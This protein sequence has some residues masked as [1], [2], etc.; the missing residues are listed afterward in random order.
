MTVPVLKIKVIPKPIIKGRMDV[1]FPANVRTEKFLKV[2]RA[3][4]TYTFDIDYTLMPDGPVSSSANAY[5]AVLDVASGLYLNVSLA[6][7]LT[8]GLDADL[9][10]IAALTGTGILVRTA[11]D[12]W[13]QRSIV[14]GA[15]MGVT[16][17]D[18]VAGNPTITI[19]DPELVALAGLTSAADKLPYFDGAGSAALADFTAYARSLLDDVDAGTA[20]TT[21][22]LVIGTD[23]QAYDSDLD[24]W[25][26]KTAPTGDAVGTSDAQTLT[27]KTFDVGDN[28]V[29][30]T[31]AEFN[32]ALSDGDFA[33]LAGT[34]TLTNKT[35]T[36][37]AITTPSGLVKGDV[38]LGN[39]DNTS[40]ATKN[41]AIVTLTNKTISGASNTLTVRLG[42]DVTGNLPVSNLNSGTSASSS[43]FWRGDGTWATPAGSGNVSGPASSTDNALARFDSTTG[44]IL[45]DSQVTLDDSGNLSPATNDGGGLGTASTSWSD[46]YLASGGVLNFANGNYT[47]T[48][49]SGLLTFS[50]SAAVGGNLSFSTAASITSSTIG[51]QLTLGPLGSSPGILASVNSNYGQVQIRAGSGMVAG[52]SFQLFYRNGSVVGDIN[53]NGTG[54]TYSTT[55][56]ERLKTRFDKSGIDWGRRLD[57]LWVGDYEFKSR[58]G[59][60]M[61]G[62]TAQRTEKVF[63]QAVHKPSSEGGVWTVDYGQLSPLA[64]WGAKDARE[65]ISTIEKKIAELEITISRLTERGR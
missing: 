7:L 35:L 48:H 46:V 59:V 8:S 41:A 40:D 14:A 1:R 61:L 60:T 9:Q 10:A 34:E 25:A 24:D 36:S 44:T 28:S 2:D 37:P 16:D 62:V 47:V 65:R 45:Q 6:S 4:G 39:V 58:P 18:G 12:T 52:N 63:P 23:V 54:V 38:G 29:T 5:L 33:T 13:A 19:T 22:G 42:S 32:A 26:G 15:L 27:N 11:S 50:G 64:L 17:G 57:E 43:T 3:N 20:R 30:G 21:L 53:Y 56:D 51:S 49:S 31:T 55:S